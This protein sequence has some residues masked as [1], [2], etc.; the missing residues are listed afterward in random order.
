MDTKLTPASLLIKKAEI[1]STETHL[2]SKIDMSVSPPNEKKID[3]FTPSV[4][5]YRCNSDIAQKSCIGIV[6]CCVLGLAVSSIWP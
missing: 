3:L 5:K 4:V 1:K 2:D 6:L